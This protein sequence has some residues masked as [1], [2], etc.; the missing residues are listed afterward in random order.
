MNP[1]PTDPRLRP[2]QRKALEILSKPGRQHVLCTSPTGSGKSL[3]FETLAR[4]QGARTLIL[5]PLRALAR[6]QISRLQALGV[7]HSPGFKVRTSQPTAWVCTPEELDHRIRDGFRATPDTLLVV[8]ECHCIWEWGRDFRPVYSQIQH[9]ARTWSIERSLWLSATLPAARRIELQQSLGTELHH[10]G[11]FDLHPQLTIRRVILEPFYRPNFLA[12][13]LIQNPEPGIVFCATRS[14][15]EAVGRLIRSI[16]GSRTNPTGVATYHAGLTREERLNIEKLAASRHLHWLSAT[17]AF[18]MGMDFDHFKWVL[19]WQPPPTLLTLV[20]MLG[21]TGR[22]LESRPKAAVLWHPAELE[23]P[24]REQPAES[25]TI[26]AFLSSD[27]QPRDW[28]KTYFGA[29]TKS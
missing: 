7:E 24:N 18:G 20:Q 25:R 3:I 16:A 14:E 26:Y 2:F 12:E 15:C 1:T 8:D 11:Q 9:W 6:Q 29:P 28:L 22:L 10:V 13:W 17:S 19:I 5:S 23:R 21:R 4:T 27:Q